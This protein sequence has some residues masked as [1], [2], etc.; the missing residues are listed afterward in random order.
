MPKDEFTKVVL[1]ELNITVAQPLVEN[2][3]DKRL[4]AE[5]VR[6]V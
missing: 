6:N 1:V 4:A 5:V 3:P 2:S